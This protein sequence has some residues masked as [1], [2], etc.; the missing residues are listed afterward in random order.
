M[1]LFSLLLVLGWERLFKLTDYWQFDSRIEPLFLYQRRYSLVN[2]LLLLLLVLLITVLVTQLSAGLFFG[3]VYWILWILLATLCIGAGRIREHYHSWLELAGRDDT[4][5]HLAMAGEITLIHGAPNQS[6]EETFLRELQ[7]ALL[8][9]N[10]RFYLAPMLCLVAG[11]RWGPVLLVSYAFLRASQS[12][13]ARHKTPDERKQSGVDRILHWVDWIPVRLVGI[14]YVLLG[15]GE[16]A[17][18]VWLKSLS[19]IH[20]SQYQILTQLAQFS[21]SSSAADKVET[22][23]LAVS[24]AKRVSIAIIVTV[25]LLI[26]YGALV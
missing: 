15:S 16:R 26:I 12:W 3:L 14:A 6:D 17:L 23:R 10:Y 8:W 11:G 22:P 20:T 5:A 24:M 1:T 7:N 13:F 4:A 2:T 9:V 21:L 19:D 18:P 25:A